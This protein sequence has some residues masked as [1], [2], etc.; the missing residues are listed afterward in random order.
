[1]SE[2]RDELR[3]EERVRLR[4]GELLAIVSFWALLAVLTAAGRLL[5]PR[6]PNVSET[7]SSALV[8][9]SFIQFTMWA[10]LTPPIVLLVNRVANSRWTPARRTLI[11][12]VAGLVI[13]IVVD[14]ILRAFWVRLLPPPPGRIRFSGTVLSH[15]L[16]FEFLDDFIVYLAVLGAAFARDYY[17]RYRRHAD[18]ARDLQ[19]ELNAARLAAL[20]TQLNPHFLFNTL[21]AISALVGN[22]PAGVRKMV[23]R[24]SDLLRHTLDEASEPEVPLAQEIELLRRYLGIMEV[25]FQGGLDVKLTVDP[26][27]RDALVPN[28]ILQPLVENAFKHGLSGMTEGAS[29]D[30]RGARIGDQVVLTVTD[31]GPG[32][33]S[34]EMGVGLR[35]TTERLGQLYGLDYS[36]ALKGGSGGGAVAEIRLPYHTSPRDTRLIHG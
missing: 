7:I 2:S 34:D 33:R 14:A 8:T 36:F 19:A 5:D 31:N 26:A 35:N 30:I 20:R 18:E 10:L 3:T 4:S 22:D 11:L 27:V 6:V 15:V 29:I 25:R 16:R 23:T 21:N 17:L 28:M 32:P 12:V 13:A 9:L 24:L 1:M